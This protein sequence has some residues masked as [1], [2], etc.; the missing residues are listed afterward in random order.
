[1]G[2][3]PDSHDWYTTGEGEIIGI[4]QEKINAWD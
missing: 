1:M 3:G 4:P 2:G